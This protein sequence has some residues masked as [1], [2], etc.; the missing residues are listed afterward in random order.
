MA[1]NQ[2]TPIFGES[3]PYPDLP[4]A[5]VICDD[6]L[7]DLG[8]LIA[9]R[10]KAA[11]PFAGKY[12]LIDFALSNCVNSGI[13]TVGLITQYKPRSL[14]THVAYGRPWDLDRRS[15]GLTVLHPYQARTAMRWYT[16]SADAVYQN[17]NFVMRQQTDHVL[18]LTGSEVTAFDFAPMIAQHKQT[19]ADVTIAVIRP[20]SYPM[21]SHVQI[22]V[23]ED[24]TVQILPHSSS[25]LGEHIMVGA[26]IFSTEVLN[27]RLSEDAARPESGH[28]LARD[29]IP[30]MIDEGDQVMAYLCPAYWNSVQTIPEYWQ[31]GLDL[32]SDNPRLNLQDAAWPI[33]T[34]SNVYPPTRVSSGARITHSLISEGCIVD[35]TVEYS[36]LSPGVCIAPG[37][38]VRHSVVM[39]RTSVEERAA[40]ENAILDMDVIAG[41]HSRVGRAHRCAPTSYS[42][43]PVQLTV[44]E[45]GTH[46]PA[47]QIIDP[48]DASQSCLFAQRYNLSNRPVDTG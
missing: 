28:D 2:E 7:A 22:M 42:D 8:C 27:W 5:L 9:E 4:L 46:I 48:E 43:I 11:L 13:E 19:H 29:V 35:G 40:V 45:K 38:V 15:G 32:L 44:I 20:E 12:R 25:S 24:G 26:M 31:A 17:Q 36:I 1:S 21:G 39:H 30:A 47:H 6:T 18:I 33:R 37:A 3:D 34:Q 41:P 14:Y 10:C 16:G 23:R